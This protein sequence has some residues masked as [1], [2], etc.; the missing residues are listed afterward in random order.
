MESQCDNSNKNP[1]TDY[2][3][4]FGFGKLNGDYPGGQAEFLRVPYADQN[5]FKIPDQ[6]VPDEKVLFLSDIVPTAY[7]SVLDSRVKLPNQ[8]HLRQKHHIEDRSDA[9]ASFHAKTL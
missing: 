3:G 4:L 7:W 9:R 5:S 2:G 1:E 8:Q 6:S